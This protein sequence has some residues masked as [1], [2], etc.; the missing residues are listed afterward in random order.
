M[1]LVGK[2]VFML[3]LVLS[4]GSL[5]PSIQ[6]QEATVTVFSQG[7]ALY[8]PQDMARSQKDAVMD[9]QAQAI[10]QVLGNYLNPSQMATQYNAI[11]E[12][13]LKNPE[14]YVDNY[15]VFTE[16]S[17]GGL[18]R[19]TGE[20]T[21]NVETLRKDLEEMGWSPALGNTA[22]SAGSVAQ[23][24]EPA[25]PVS[26]KSADNGTQQEGPRGIVLSK[27]EVLWTVAERWEEEWVIP[28]DRRDP[29]GIFAVSVLQEFQDYQTS[30]RLPG[31]GAIAADDRGNISSNQA[32]SLAKSLGIPYAV[33]GTL[34]FRQNQSQGAPRLS[35]NL[36][37]LNVSSGKVQG[38]VR[39]EVEV[40]EG[41][42][43]EGA[44]ELALL[45][46]PQLERLISESSR[47][48]T[49]VAV[50]EKSG[51]PAEWVLHIQAG[52]QYSHWMELEKV[53]RERFKSMQVKRM[54]FGVQENLI[55][56]VGLEG[57]SLG[58]IDGIQLQGG[59]QVKVTAFSAEERSISLSFSEPRAGKT[60]S[61]Q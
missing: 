57:Q 22:P 40:S 25:P 6:A 30:V 48:G 23:E 61:T 10:L 27:Q 44:M 42:N 13:M 18:Y 7:Q 34:V 4:S 45:V 14:H 38:E 9:F 54:E 19:I 21:L 32:L 43:Q 49:T 52:S 33:V 59:W 3:A 47:G 2:L 58:G 11:E 46:V 20:V 5:T 35:A 28:S 50:A 60:E 56:L 31:A 41:S 17:G 55:H 51:D 1:K 24:S 39:K 36:R 12:K 16:S 8:L 29:R 26:A 15:R 53:L 37:L